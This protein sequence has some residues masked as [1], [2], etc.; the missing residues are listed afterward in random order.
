M[1]TTF[2]TIS[3]RPP[4]QP[5]IISNCVIEEYAEP[6]LT[7]S[8]RKKLLS[9]G[10]DQ[11]LTTLLMKHFPTFCVH[12][13]AGQALVTHCR[14][15]VFMHELLTDLSNRVDLSVRVTTCKTWN[16][17]SGPFK[18]IWIELP[19]LFNWFQ[20][21]VSLLTY[22]SSFSSHWHSASGTIFWPFLY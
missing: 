10:K 20:T 17:G 6:T 14:L 19:Y 9:L 1:N 18:Q 15:S 21:L 5:I 2:R 4:N 22:T 12:Q 8:T 7:C 13:Y 3:P 11:F 16:D